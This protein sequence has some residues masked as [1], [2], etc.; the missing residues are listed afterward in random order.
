MRGM[1]RFTL[2]AAVFVLLVIVL[3][4]G[5][6]HSPDKASSHR[7][8]RQARAAVLAPDLTDASRT[9]SSTFAA[10][11]LVPV[12]RLG[13]LV[14]HLSGGAMACF[15]RCASRVSSRSS[16]RLKD[17]DAQALSWAPAAR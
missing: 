5:I 6:K 9:V 10:R 3:A 16:A 8:D 13:E 12:E 14:R 15:S 4:I 11:T 1:N 17:D 7:S 2:P